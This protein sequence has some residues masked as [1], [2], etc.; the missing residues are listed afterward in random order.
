MSFRQAALLLLAALLVLGIPAAGQAPGPRD[1]RAERII[2]A[3]LIW[4]LV[5]ELN[6]T[7]QQIA[8]IF[9][10]IKALKDLR[11]ELGRRKVAL[12]R[13]LRALL[14]QQPRNDDDI[15]AK[16]GELEQLRL[17]VQRQRQRVLR[18][19]HASLTVEQRA[20]F[21]LIQETFEADTI[22]LLDEVRKLVEEGGRRQ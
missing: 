18:E 2:E 11:I 21:T 13:E 12:Q 8:R 22:R 17:Q 7:D 10:R 5:D 6:L 1:A 14:A 15:R 9:P 19:I 4:R 20:Q 16:I 3:L